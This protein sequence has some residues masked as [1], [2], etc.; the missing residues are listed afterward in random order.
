MSLTISVSSFPSK[1]APNA[2]LR[3]V[4][5]KHDQR[6]ASRPLRMPSAIFGRFAP[7]GPPAMPVSRAPLLFGFRSAFSSSLSAFADARNG[8]R[9]RPQFFASFASR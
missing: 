7:I 6:L 3:H 4:L 2:V 8:I 5:A 1:S 9:Q